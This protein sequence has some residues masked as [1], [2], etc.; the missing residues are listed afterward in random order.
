M[1]SMNA[2]AKMRIA[3]CGVAVVTAIAFT[4]CTSTTT[5]T[6]RPPGARLYLN[7]EPVGTTP[8]TMSD[9]RIVGSQTMVRL[10]L[11]GYEPTNGV[12]VRNEEFD[13]GACIG[14]V[15][16]LFPFLWIFGYRP[17]HAF[18]L[19]PVGSTP[20]GQPPGYPPPPGSYPPPPGGYP[21][22]PAGYPPPPP[23]AGYPPP[24]AGSAPPPAYPPPPQ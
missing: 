7:G 14:G 2:K 10:E 13:V 22:P 3:R 8:Y 17:V 4:A 11:P 18:E 9:T 1:S 20:W 16:L 15:F 5:I 23:P 24:P 19:R 6:S 12:I 21:P